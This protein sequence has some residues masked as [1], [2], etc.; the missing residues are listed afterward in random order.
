MAA[1]PSCSTGA[2][3]S[4]DQ[5]TAHAAVNQQGGKGRRIKPQPSRL[6][7]N[8]PDAKN[9]TV[10]AVSIHV[11]ICVKT[12]AEPIHRS[13]CATLSLGAAFPD[14]QG[15][16]A[17]VDSACSTLSTRLINSSRGSSKKHST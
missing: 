16:S 6:A 4:A 10:T 11:T 15:C 9:R 13:P 1:A 8:L 17:L 7:H 14:I 12:F 2:V 5:D 3:P